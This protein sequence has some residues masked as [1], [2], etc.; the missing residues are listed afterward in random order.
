MLMLR[1]GLGTAGLSTVSGVIPRLSQDL[2]LTR[3][4]PRDHLL[5]VDHPVDELRLVPLERTQHL[6]GATRGHAG[7]VR[8]SLNRVSLGTV[9][10]PLVS[11][12]SVSGASVSGAFVR[13]EIDRE[14][15]VR[16]VVRI[17]ELLAEVL[18]EEVLG[19]HRSE[20]LGQIEVGRNGR[21]VNQLRAASCRS[22]RFPVD[23]FRPHRCQVD[24]FRVDRFQVEVIVR[25]AISEPLGQLEPP[26]SLTLRPE[27]LELGTLLGCRRPVAVSREERIDTARLGSIAALAH[28]RR[29]PKPCT[30]VERFSNM[31][32]FLCEYAFGQTA[33]CRDRLRPV[34]GGLGKLDQRK[35]AGL[36]GLLALVHGGLGKLDQPK[37]PGLAGKS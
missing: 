33:R 25:G 30:R 6:R 20:Y 10:A 16:E 3:L 24:R 28:R 34:H 5:E 26:I 19:R 22:H 13:D 32:G 9:S 8:V 14:E 7:L 18:I 4:R 29:I 15:I 35:R 37:W 21:A 17:Q 23:R 36:A 12:A 11:G 2:S 31:F 1:T 27:H